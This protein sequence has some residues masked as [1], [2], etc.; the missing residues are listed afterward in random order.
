MTVWMSE[1]GYDNITSTYEE[2]SVLI[3]AIYLMFC[4]LLGSAAKGSFYRSMFGWAFLAFLF[5]PV[6]ALVFLI[7]AGPP[8]EAKEQVEADLAKRKR[9]IGGV[10]DGS[11]IEATCKACGAVVSITSRE[12][13]YSPE[14][15]PWRVIC[16]NCD[17]P[18]DTGDVV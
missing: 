8:M 10:V 9:E 14:D 2:Y 17:Q 11:H 16:K 15:E 13:V 5:S 3:W 6:V 4:Y 12:G 18:I 1:I 7:V